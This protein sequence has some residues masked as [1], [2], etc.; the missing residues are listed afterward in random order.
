MH[1]SI[2]EKEMANHS[3]ILAWRVPWRVEAGRLQSL[4][5]QQLGS[6]LKRAQ[7]F[8]T[9]CNPRD[10]NTTRLLC[11]WNFP[12]KN[13]GAGCHLLLLGIFPTQRLN[14]CLLGLL[15]WRAD[16]LSL[17]HLGNPNS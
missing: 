9:L 12:G 15:H 5:L 14:P 7:L 3:R 6:V 16:F 11:P 4:G 8:P 10:Y 1:V 13:S 17:S 2:W